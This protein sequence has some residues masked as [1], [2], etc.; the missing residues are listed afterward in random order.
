[1]RPIAV[2]HH[3]ELTDRLFREQRMEAVREF[4]KRARQTGVLTGV[5]THK[6]E[7]IADIEERGWDLDF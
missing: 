1:M 5:S 4:L 7:V 6:P 2:A 3:G